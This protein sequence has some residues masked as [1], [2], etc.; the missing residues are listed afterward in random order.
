MY[1]SISYDL[2]WNP[3]YY[4]PGKRSSVKITVRSYQ[5]SYIQASSLPRSCYSKYEQETSCFPTDASQ[6]VELA[7]FCGYMKLGA[8]GGVV[9]EVIVGPRTSSQVVA[10]MLRLRDGMQE[11]EEE[12]R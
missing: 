6:D 12:C 3:D 4:T 5:D 8:I 9:I 2:S 11:G 10:R 7:T 1:V